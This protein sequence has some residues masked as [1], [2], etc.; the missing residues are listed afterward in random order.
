MKNAYSKRSSKRKISSKYLGNIAIIKTILVIFTFCLIA[1]ITNILNYPWQTIQVI[2][3]IGL[4]VLLGSFNG[5]FYS[6]FQ[7][8]EKMEYQSLGNV[9]NSILMLIGTLLAILLGFTVVGFAVIYLVVSAIL[10]IYSLFVC[11]W[12]FVLGK[13]EVDW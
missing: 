11:I 12:K 8:Y 3:L 4:S 7:S 2:Y 6:I 1:I 5:L 9:L 13:I 10:L